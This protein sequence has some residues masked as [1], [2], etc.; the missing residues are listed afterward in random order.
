MH[1]TQRRKRRRR[2]TL[3]PRFG[4]STIALEIGLIRLTLQAAKDEEKREVKPVT[5]LR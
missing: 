2:P 5:K 4:D 3:T 1:P